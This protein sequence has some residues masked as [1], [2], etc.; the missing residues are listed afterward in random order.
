MLIIDVEIPLFDF[1]LLRNLFHLLT[2]FE[3]TLTIN[4]EGNA[5]V[6]ILPNLIS[7]ETNLQEVIYNLQAYYSTVFYAIFMKL[8][9]K[10]PVDIGVF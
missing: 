4:N 7:D 2:Q 6:N 10:I 8:Q 9:K 1:K 5:L 3:Q